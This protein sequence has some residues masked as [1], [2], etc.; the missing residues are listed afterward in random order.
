MKNKTMK[1]KTM[2][3]KT[4]K[5]KTM[6]NKKEKI[7]IGGGGKNNTISDRIRA[8][9]ILESYHY[10]NLLQ[11]VSAL[12]P[13]LQANRKNMVVWRGIRNPVK[14]DIGFIKELEKNGSVK[15]TRLTSTAS[16]PSVAVNFCGSIQLDNI[17]TILKINLQEGFPYIDVNDSI[18]SVRSHF[19]G[20]KEYL[21]LPEIEQK[22]LTFELVKKTISPDETTHD[23]LL[24]Q[25]AI[26]EN[27][28]EG[29]NM[30]WYK[31]PTRQYK[32][33]EKRF[34][35]YEINAKYI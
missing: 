9:R 12:R 17:C 3:N 11:D 8:T 14:S 13:L 23:T 7:C 30:Y 25:D 1:N 16:T 31:H 29:Q 27:E 28:K 10:G 22:T 33:L 4:M 20:E 24:I 21:L 35:I 19:A 6:K 34:V 2:K 15:I 18:R 5:N 26:Y 32:R